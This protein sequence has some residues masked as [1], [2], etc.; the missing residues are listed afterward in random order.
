MAVRVTNTTETPY[1]IKRNTQI[2][3]VSV[4]TPEQ[5]Q[6][7]K[8]VFMVI[9]SLILEGDPDLT[10]YLNELLRTNQPEQQS[11][12]FWFPTPESPGRIEDHTPIQTRILKE[13]CELKAKEKKLNP[14]NETKTKQKRNFLK[15]LIGPIHC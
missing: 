7:I 11:D 10:A 14:K 9:L 1:L 2:A 3:E 15:G 13:L 6:L 4:V 12:R 8:Q 5:A